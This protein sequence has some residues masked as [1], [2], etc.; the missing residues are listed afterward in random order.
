MQHNLCCQSYSSLEKVWTLFFSAKKV[1]FIILTWNF[2][3]FFSLDSKSQGCFF[4]KNFGFDLKINFRICRCIV[5]ENLKNRILSFSLHRDTLERLSF[6]SLVY[7]SAF[8]RFRH[9][10]SPRV[11]QNSPP[12]TSLLKIFE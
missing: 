4:A 9:S 5:S 10:K 6:W 12:K 1:K 8:A 3:R 11:L 2:L 7:F